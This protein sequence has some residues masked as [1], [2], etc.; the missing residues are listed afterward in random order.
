MRTEQCNPAIQRQMEG[1]NSASSR[2]WKN[3]EPLSY[4]G[5]K[6]IIIKKKV[7]SELLTHDRYHYWYYDDLW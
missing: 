3:S 1:D 5:Q 2:H 4:N 7:T 6:N